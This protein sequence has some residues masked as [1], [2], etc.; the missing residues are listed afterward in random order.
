MIIQFGVKMLPDHHVQFWRFWIHKSTVAAD[1]IIH[2]SGFML[3][4]GLRL[5]TNR[6]SYCD[7]TSGNY[8]LV[9]LS[10]IVCWLV[11]RDMQPV[12]A[13]AYHDITRES[14]FITN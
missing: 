14:F 11:H 4:T 5:F 1:R 8:N 2:D 10:Q 7:V 3:Q 13:N 6:T 9:I 12:T